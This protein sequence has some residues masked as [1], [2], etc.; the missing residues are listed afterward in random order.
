MPPPNIPPPNLFHV[1]SS[2]TQNQRELR[3]GHKGG[4][5]WF[6]GLSGSGKTTLAQAT[7]RLLFARGYQVFVLDGDNIRS[8]LC[9][10]LGFDAASR[11]ENIRRIGEVAALFAQAGMVVIAAFISPYHEDRVKARAIAPELFHNIYISAD[12]ATCEAR[13]VKGLYAKARAG[14]VAHFTGISAPYEV[15]A[16]PDLVLDTMQHDVAACC[17]QLVAYVQ[18]HFGDPDRIAQD[19]VNLNENTA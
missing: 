16:Q 10:D 15:P 12:L 18:Q 7:Q 9:A 14:D 2:I 5:L 4:V 6:T 11:R 3:N 1:E 17:A 8:G 19:R 13:D